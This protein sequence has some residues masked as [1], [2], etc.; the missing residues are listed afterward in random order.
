MMYRAAFAPDF[1]RTLHS[2]VHAEFRRRKSVEA[3]ARVVRRPWTL[4]AGTA[5]TI[6]SGIYNAAKL[7]LYRSELNRLSRRTQPSPAIVLKP[8]LSRQ[9]AA[10]PSEQP[11]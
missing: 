11:H 6:A 2:A 4:R 7:P 9:D 3:F 8:V 10:V 1:Y 5:R